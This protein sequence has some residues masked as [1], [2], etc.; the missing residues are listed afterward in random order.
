[1]ELLPIFNV[2]RKYNTPAWQDLIAK[3]LNAVE[4]LPL[5]QLGKFIEN[6]VELPSDI[7]IL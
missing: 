6:Q 4:V 5:H 7:N 1:M 2:S 3:L